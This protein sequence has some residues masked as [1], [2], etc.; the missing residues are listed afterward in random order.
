MHGWMVDTQ[1]CTKRL[2]LRKTHTHTNACMGVHTLKFILTLI[3]SQPQIHMYAQII[4]QTH[5]HIMYTH[6]HKLTHTH[7]NT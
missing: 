7:T 3:H 5:T 2:E 1:T 4:A 6:V